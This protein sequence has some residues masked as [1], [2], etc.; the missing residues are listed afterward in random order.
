MFFLNMRKEVFLDKN[1]FILLCLFVSFFAVGQPITVS[2]TQYTPDQLVRDVLIKTPCAQI[3]NIKWLTGSSFP[4]GDKSNG[5]GYFQNTN[6]S[7]DMADGIVLSTGKVTST[8]GPRG[9]NGGSSDGTQDAW[10]D[11]PQLTT[12]MHNVLNNTDN[13][14]NATILEFDFMPF[15]DDM[16]FNFIFASEEYGTYQCNY[17]D[18]FAFFLTNTV[19]NTTT[20][21]ALVPNTTLPISVTTIRD[22]A[23]NNGNNGVCGDGN[24][25]S[26]NETYFDS[27][28]ATSTTNAINFN[29]QTV[30]MVAQ[31]TVVPFTKYHIKM[32]IQDRGDSGVDSAVFIEGGSFN[33]GNLDLGDPL[34]IGDGK[35][36]C[37]GDSYTLQAGMNPNLFT[38]EWFKDGVK[39][40]GQ[41]GPNLVV[42][43]TGDY[44]VHAF[45]PN[46]NCALESEPV[47]IE[48]YDYISITPPKN[49]ALCPSAGA[50]TRFDLKDAVVG[51]TANPNILFSFYTTQQDAQNDTNAIPD[52]YNLA[53]NATVPVTI[54]VR[55]YELNNPCPYIGSFNLNFIN[56]VLTLNHL[57]DLKICEGDTVQTFD[58]T[59]QT[60]LVYNNA[61]GYTVTYHLNSADATT[62]QSPIPTAN[63]ATYNGIH[64][65]RIWVRVTSTTNPLSYGVT[66]FYLFKYRL[67]VLQNTLLPLTACENGTTGLANF[68][69]NLAYNTIPLSPVGVSLEFYTTQQDAQIGN[70]A[71]MLPSAYTAPAGTIYVRVRNLDGD[72]FVVVPLQL[73]IINTP[74]ANSIAPLTYCDLNNDGFG[75]FNLDATRVLIAGN[76]MP[77]NSVVTF[78]ETQGDADANVGAIVNTGTYINKVKDQQTIYVRVGFINSTCYTTVPLVLKVNKAPAVTQIRNIIVCDINNDGVET[79]NLRSKEAD[80]MVGLNAANYTITYHVSASSAMSGTGVIG[81]P[82]SFSTSV[83]KVV[84]VRVTDNTTGCFVVVKI[85]LILSSMPVVQNPLPPYV[86]CDKNGDG[87]EVFDLASRKAGIIGTQQGLDVT[88][89]YTN[90]DAQSGTAALPNQYQNVAANVQTIYVRVFN[91]STNCF[92]VTTLKLEVKANPVINV[93]TTPYVICSTSFGTI[94]LYLY[95]KDL[96]DATGQNYTFQFFETQANAENN[97]S[98][99]GNPVAYNN[100]KPSNPTVWIRVQDP[101]SGCYSVYAISFQLVVPP[102]LPASLPKIVECDVL[103]DTQDESTL[104][105]LTEQNAA[106]LAAQTVPGTYQIHYF[107]TQASANSNTNWIVDPTQFQNTTNPQTIWVRIEDTSKPGSCGRIMSFEIEVAAPF[108]LKQPS[109]IILCDTDLPND[110]KREFD[111]TIRENELLLHNHH[112]EQLLLITVPSKMLKTDLI[113]Y[114][115]QNNSTTP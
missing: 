53:N 90:A 97:V 3:S 62:G 42:T 26:M 82:T 63:L 74:T 44:S 28:N 56:C 32:V 4:N 54:W 19:T 23:Y 89:H 6:P 39:I 55:A 104:F 66:S 71:L 93:P 48:F 85:D 51:V 38:F 88:F 47:R 69:L 80:M 64:G 22:A 70:T 29:G 31:S 59:V 46:V 20:N 37:V 109:P 49:L 14:H 30:K 50:T 36:L 21:L 111:L 75:E 5:I 25:A 77:A 98:P 76:P 2:T 58:L 105:N 73:Q 15:T 40:P 95:G 12:Y 87:F 112:L 65:E 91:A 24:P 27:Y 110:G 18:A 43:Q 94:N 107:T 60:P 78:H 33:I 101:V 61:A 86:L 84:Y 8:P 1:W 96:V 79:L 106:L 108:V 34:L 57:D 17:S 7:L 81:N 114:Q 35:G 100:L 83:S 52:L 113:K 11:D 13:Y 67:P 99:I 103:G 68:D 9:T 45:V 72:C 92:V 115:I 102:V 10:P 16:R 41:T